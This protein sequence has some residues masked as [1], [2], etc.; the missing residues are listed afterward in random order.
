MRGWRHPG[1]STVS[2]L[3]GPLSS[4]PTGVTRRVSHAPREAG[5][6]QSKPHDF[7]PALAGWHRNESR[8]GSFSFN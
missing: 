8:A 2:S 7:P 3:G 5:G 6:S 1:L 4:T